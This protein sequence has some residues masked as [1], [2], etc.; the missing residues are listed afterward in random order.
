MNERFFFLN[1]DCPLELGKMGAAIYDLK[2]IAIYA[3]DLKIGRVIELCREGKTLDEI[4][5]EDNRKKKEAVDYLK[6]LEKYNLGFFSENYTVIEA[7]LPYFAIKNQDKSKSMEIDKLYIEITKLC[8]LKCV[9]CLVQSGIAKCSCTRSEKNDTSN[10][11]SLELWKKVLDDAEILKCKELVITGGEPF[12]EE[13]KILE[14]L[15]YINHNIPKIRIKSNLLLI[16][17]EIIRMLNYFKVG[18]ESNFFSH[19]SHI[20][21]QITRCKG[22][23]SKW[24]TNC[25]RLLDAGIDVY[26]KNEI[27]GVNREY[28]KEN[29][30]FLRGIGVDSHNIW[31]SLI[32]SPDKNIWPYECEEI[33]KDLNSISGVSRDLYF[34]NKERNP[35]WY[36]KIAVTSDGTIQPCLMATKFPMGN[37]MRK[38]LLDIFRVGLQIKFWTYTK[39][40]V[41]KCRNCEFRYACSDCRPIESKDNK[42]NGASRFCKVY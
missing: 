3:I 16:N 4:F 34:Y 19:K 35:C 40:K 30:D 6:K 41:N 15:K 31:T 24:V 14:I 23:L 36:G 39:D 7:L 8:N 2:K 5:G 1:Q 29:V 25:K 18:I 32:Y 10:E 11:V 13:K 42:I 37:I 26:I 21:D 17:E 28:R 33:Y 9:H 12:L 38:S 27:M 20:Y 22:G